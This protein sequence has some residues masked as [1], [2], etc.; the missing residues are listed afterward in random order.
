MSLSGS[1]SL[2]VI[3]LSCNF[4]QPL[5]ENSSSRLFVTFVHRVETVKHIITVI[6]NQFL[7]PIAH[8]FRQGR[9]SKQERNCPPEV[10]FDNNYIR[11]VT[12]HVG[13]LMV[14]FVRNN[15]FYL[16]HFYYRP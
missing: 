10:H 1:A 3:V 15:I 7:L 8:H 13:Q 14:V 4:S 12:C 2:S 5:E 11:N 6:T 9:D 16:M